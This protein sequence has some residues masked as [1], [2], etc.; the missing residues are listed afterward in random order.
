MTDDTALWLGAEFLV[1]PIHGTTWHEVPG[2]YIFAGQRFPGGAW[3]AVYVGQTVSFANRL[4]DHP[5][6]AEAL[7]VGAVAIHAR[8]IPTETERT[9][10][11]R[12]LI[13][14]YQPELNLLYR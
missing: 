4:A 12:Q 9:S 1:Y 13:E 11:E 6:T 10:L 5:R 3:H 14:A 7:Q 8:V 2:V